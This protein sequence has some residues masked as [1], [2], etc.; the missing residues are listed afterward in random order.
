MKRESC[1][2]GLLM[3]S[4]LQGDREAGGRLVKRYLDPVYAFSFHILGDG[5][6]AAEASQELFLRIWQKPEQWRADR[7]SFRAW[8]FTVTANICRDR[9]RHNSRRKNSA[10]PEEE[11]FSDHRRGPCEELLEG[12]QK[13][14]IAAAVK[15]L[16]L[17]QRIA[18]LLSVYESL[19]LKEIASVLGCSRRAVESLLGR[20]RRQ[21]QRELAQFFHPPS[22]T[23]KAY[24]KDREYGKERYALS[25]AQISSPEALPQKLSKNLPGN[26]PGGLF[27]RWV[28]GS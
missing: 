20:A 19:S 1:E 2:D 14:I 11:Q 4:I 25:S 27:E 9:L 22:H 12:E 24:S 3:A 13:E 18:L 15:A 7:G 26:L 10:M 8:L 5:E 16:P 28:A 23:A 21:L 6:E 17:R